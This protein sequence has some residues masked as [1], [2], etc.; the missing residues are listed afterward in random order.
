MIC[1][2]LPAHGSGVN[3]SEPRL[4]WNGNGIVEAPLLCGSGMKEAVPI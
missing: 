2:A 1:V 4:N 3:K